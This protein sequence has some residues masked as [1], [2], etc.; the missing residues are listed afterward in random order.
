MLELVRRI[1]C[2]LCDIIG[3]EETG[4][5]GKIS[6]AHFLRNILVSDG[7][8]NNYG[9]VDLCPK[10]YEMFK[11]DKDGI[12]EKIEA[13]RERNQPITTNEHWSKP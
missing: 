7:W 9:K 11:Q 12:M 4:T 13:K 3:K 10:C 1:R 8:F 2:D 5:Q 6:E